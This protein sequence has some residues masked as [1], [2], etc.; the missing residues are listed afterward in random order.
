MN[1]RDI[2]IAGGGMVGISLALLLAEQLPAN[3]R[4]TL[5]EGFRLPP[6]TNRVPDYHPA[7]D[8]R[9]TALSYRS[10]CLYEHCGVWETLSRH[11]CAIETIHVSSRGRFGSSL[12]RASDHDWPAL[13]HVVENPW[14]GQALLHVLRERPAI[15][16]LNPAR[17]V[18]AQASPGGMQLE[19]A[20]QGAP[21]ELDCRLLV[22]ADGAESGLR[23]RLGIAVER[24]PYGQHALICN[25]ATDRPHRGCAF[26]RFTDQGP[27]ALLPLRPAEGGA[28]RSALVWTLP[29]ERAD[30]LT[31]ADDD[32]FLR[33]LGERFGYRLGR[34]LQASP[35]QSYPLALL[36]SE[37]QVRRGLV[38]MGNA[39]HAL[40]PVAGQGFNLALRDCAALAETLGAALAR[41]QEPGELAVLQAYARRQQ[42]DQ[43][44]TIGLSDLLPGL[45]MQAD[46]VLGVV[47]D[48]ALSG[49]D[50]VAPFKKA[51]VRQA[52]GMRAGG[53]GT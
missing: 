2:V 21:A 29:P 40:H 34:F 42:A 50:W 52:A 7:F 48:L 26:E 24:K 23:E 25:V 22:V 53:V 17:V 31:S 16:L 1:K 49:L 38:V 45:F 51:F 5:V 28:H 10:R 19:L 41:D 43:R 27:M 20:G 32:A 18:G 3:R 13:G 9:S 15:E 46:P 30:A 44:L 12:L 4:I 36:R 39:A 33:A 47:R 6:A 35:R 37:E 8:A 14:L 11:T